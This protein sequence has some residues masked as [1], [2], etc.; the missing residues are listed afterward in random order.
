[1]KNLYAICLCLSS[2]GVFS[3]TNVISNFVD[4]SHY[5]ARHLY[6]LPWDDT[7]LIQVNMEFDMQSNRL[8]YWMDNV[9][10]T[11]PVSFGIP[12]CDV[13]TQDPV[14]L[15]QGILVVGESNATGS[16]LVYYSNTNVV[17]FDL[18]PGAV[19]SNPIVEV[20]QD[21]VYVVANKDGIRQLFTFDPIA[22]T[23]N[24]VTYETS[25]VTR[26]CGEWLGNTYFQKDDENQVI[27]NVQSQLLKMDNAAPTYT[28]ELIHTVLIDTADY[29]SG[30]TTKWSNPCI[31][32]NRLYFSQG[33]FS[34][35]S[36]W[37]DSVR[38]N[39]ISF[40]SSNG[41]LQHGIQYEMGSA[42]SLISFNWNGYLYYYL[43]SGNFVYRSSDGI[44]F[45]QDYSIAQAFV[46]RHYISENGHLYFQR[47][48]I[49]D[50]HD[51]IRYNGNA[52]QVVHANRHLHILYEKDD[53][54]YLS[55][56]E[57][58]NDPGTLVL[59][60]ANWDIAEEIVT[61]PGLH[62]AFDR[63]ALFYDGYFTFIWSDFVSTDI[64]QLISTSFAS[65][66][67]LSS[68]A[69]NVH[70]NPVQSNG[71]LNVE[72]DFSGSFSILSSQG[73]IVQTGSFDAFSSAIQLPSLAD[74]VYF[75]K[76]EVGQT[77]FVVANH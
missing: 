63:A 18:V 25:D 61:F 5:A 26:A 59:L 15:S 17:L 55:N 21:R 42:Q 40:D 51:I 2:L 70:P 14:F 45:V 66:S 71:I 57:W 73:S 6:T 48:F 44:N 27:G 50:S 64:Y 77:R 41:F 65:V 30:F 75:L 53:I 43:Q 29:A 49:D 10:T 38:L 72:G 31:S 12:S 11:V 37:S 7:K 67:D 28:T 33:E 74:G 46:T 1:M 60:N 68:D 62:H 4:N 56:D 8:I 47:A 23:L 39:L 24:Q 3:Q 35:S 13:I 32:Q 34:V 22:E 76:S 54:I 20:I 58:D 9:S 52:S 16:E 36:N 19:G 69:M